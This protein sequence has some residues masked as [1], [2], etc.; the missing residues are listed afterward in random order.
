M[1]CARLARFNPDDPGTV[2]AGEFLEVSFED[3][4]TGI[5]KENQRRIFDP[6]FTTKDRGT[7]LGLAIVHHIIMAHH[8]TIDMESQ[9][10]SGTKLVTMFPL[11][12]D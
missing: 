5:P 12:K 3:T 6:F 11:I 8:A 4:G 7:G 10:D 9:V 2:A 1:S